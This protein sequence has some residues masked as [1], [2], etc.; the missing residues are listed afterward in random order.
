MMEPPMRRALLA[1][2]ATALLA[3]V[4]AAAQDSTVVYLV[5]HAE[6]ADASA[7]PPL[8]AAGEARARALAGRLAGTRLDAVLVTQYL[9][10]TATAAPVLA[11][12]RLAPWRIPT[13]GGELPH[14][15]AVAGAIRGELAGRTVLVVGHSNTVPAI[16]GRLGGRALP[17]LCEAEYAHLF[18]VVL[19]PGREPSVRRESYGAADPPGADVCER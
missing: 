8:S 6:K 16:V 1:S 7:D 4:P 5:R 19:R 9:R 14:L 17:E 3:G 15:D 13:R 12:Q 10:S 18:V 2:L 11:A